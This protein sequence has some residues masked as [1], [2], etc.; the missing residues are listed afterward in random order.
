MVYHLKQGHACVPQHPLKP[1]LLTILP[2][3][4]P[5]LEPLITSLNKSYINIHRRLSFPLLPVYVNIKALCD[6]VLVGNT[7]SPQFNIQ[8]CEC[9]FYCTYL[10][11]INFL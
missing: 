3:D 2:F 10:H 6:R 5:Y 1:I 7:D 4:N 9:E 8:S 11:N